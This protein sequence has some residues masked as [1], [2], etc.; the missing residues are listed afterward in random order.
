MKGRNG[1]T[2]IELLVVI[3]IIAILAAILFP[4]FAKARASA[5]ASECQSNM[6]Q[7]GTALKM[8]AQDNHDTYPS[9]R[10]GTALSANVQLSMTEGVKYVPGTVNWVG[11]LSP[12]M[13]AITQ[14]SAGAFCCK[15]ASSTTF[16]VAA[17]AKVSYALNANMVEMPEGAA[18]TP[19]T[20]MAVREMDRLANAILRPGN[21]STSNTI[22]PIAPFLTTQD[23]LIGGATIINPRRHSD[24]SHILF[25]DGHVKR[26][27]AS[28][29]PT[30]ISAANNWDA[31]TSQWWNCKDNS[32][33]SKTIAISP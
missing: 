11:A 18:R 28:Y 3:A 6:K 22:V 8:Y 26:F 13:E 19:D 4:V 17:S 21:Q 24:G 5:Y 14:D 12:Y 30:T 1:F 16:G 27:K 9:N 33:K 31:E 32:I 2:L 15:T 20:L 7:I 23:L 10:I 29:F 25:A